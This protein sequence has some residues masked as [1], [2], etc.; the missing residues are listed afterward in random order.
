MSGFIPIVAV[1]FLILVYYMLQWLATDLPTDQ[2]HQLDEF[3][4]FWFIKGGILSSCFGML[5]SLAYFA[6]VPGQYKLMRLASAA[7]VEQGI[8][9]QLNDKQIWDGF[10]AHVKLTPT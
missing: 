7:L 5:A 9:V 10:F 3:M 8:C 4:N 2:H 1:L 6:R